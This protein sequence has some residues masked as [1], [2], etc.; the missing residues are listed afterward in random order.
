MDDFSFTLGSFTMVIKYFISNF[1]FQTIEKSK[2][3]K[4]KNVLR[5]KEKNVS[6]SVQKV[7]SKSGKVSFWN[8]FLCKSVGFWWKLS[9]ILPVD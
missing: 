4:P 8:I 5:A 2:N 3:V 7:Q 6:Q 9:Y 1:T